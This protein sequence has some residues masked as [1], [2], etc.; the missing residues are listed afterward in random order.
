MLEVAFLRSP[1]AHGRIRGLDV[2]ERYRNKVF[3]AKDIGFAKPIVAV[4]AAGGFKPSDYPALV[5][6][7]VRFV[8]DLVAM[9]IGPTR[10][11]AED[12]AQ[13]CTLD[14]EPLPPIWDIDVALAPDA[15]RVHDHWTDNVFARTE[16]K[17]GDLEPVRNSAAV[18][19]R[20]R[21]RMGR[22]AGVSLE[23]RG[24]LAHYERRL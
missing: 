16:I 4:G 9:C 12:I 8:G 11:E 20:K 15:A 14:L 21:L 7:K 22:H 18:T 17:T 10:A 3:V 6:D 24:V 23:C 5:A 2:P 13:A 19:V 1:E